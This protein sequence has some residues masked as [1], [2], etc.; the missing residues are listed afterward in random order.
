VAAVD[1]HLGGGGA[2][3]APC[4]DNCQCSVDAL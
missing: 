2:F 1:R 4:Q 3:Q